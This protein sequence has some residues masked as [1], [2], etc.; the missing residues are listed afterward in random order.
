MFRS[1]NASLIFLSYIPSNSL[2]VPT[3]SLYSIF[4]IIV[5]CKVIIIVYLI[6]FILWN[7]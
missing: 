3:G 7:K 2:N 5:K 4:F 6:L 1:S